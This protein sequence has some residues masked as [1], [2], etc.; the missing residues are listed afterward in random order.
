[1]HDSVTNFSS[2]TINTVTYEAFSMGTT[3]CNIGNQHFQWLD[4]GNSGG[5]NRHPVIGQNIFRLKNVGGARRF[6]QLAQAWLKHG[7]CALCG[8]ACCSDRT[9]ESCDYLG[10]GCSD[11]YSSSRN[12]A[13]TTNIGPKYQVNATT[14]VHTHPVANPSGGTSSSVARRMH[15]PVTELEVSNGTGDVNATRYFGEG[16]YVG[17]DD[18]LSNNK[19]NNASYRLVSVSGSGTAWSFSAAGSTQRQQ[20]GIRAWADTDTTAS[21]P[22]VITRVVE[23]E[24]VTPEDG[25]LTGLVIIAAQATKVGGV[26]HYEWAVQNLNSDRSIYSFSVPVA[27]SAVVTNISFRDVRYWDNDGVSATGA[28]N[29][30]YDATPWNVS[31]GGGAV[32]WSCAHTYAVHQG[33]NAIRWGTMFNFRFDCDQ[34]PDENGTV[35]LVQFKPGAQTLNAS[36]VVPSVPACTG[37]VVDPISSA[38]A[39]CGVAFTSSTPSLSAGTSPLTWSLEAGAPAGMTIDPGTGVVTWPTP[40]TTGSPFTITTKATNSCGES[41]QPW[42]LRVNA[43]PPVVKPIADD[44]AVCGA[45]YTSAAPSATGG[46][47]PLAWN[48]VSGPAGMSI[49]GGTGAVTWPSPVAAGSPFTVTVEAASAFDCGTSGTQSWQVSVVI[50]DFD[51]DGLVTESD[52]PGFVDDLLAEVPICAGDINGDTLVDGNDITAMLAA[53]GL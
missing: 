24:V 11:P 47:A 45:A 15:I 32:T 38:T 20:C 19:N 10:V 8:T 46:A 25:G 9:D 48:L 33:A 13:Q 27:P 5:E 29:T 44:F 1:M 40:L 34:G 23:T 31:T 50:G 53:L 51:A 28:S 2:A 43:N 41:S 52:L 12:G 22:D 30:T 49:D 7:F 26:W 16:Q 3:S 36:T 6:E 4:N 21:I 17:S 18:S 37:P 14:G 35:T 42:E 39:D